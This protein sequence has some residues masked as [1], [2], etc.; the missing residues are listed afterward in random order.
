MYVEP[1][2]TDPPRRIDDRSYSRGSKVF[3]HS[4]SISIEYYSIIQSSKP[5]TTNP[6]IAFF[7]RVQYRSTCWRKAFFFLRP[8]LPIVPFQQSLPRQRAFTLMVT[9]YVWGSE[10]NPKPKMAFRGVLTFHAPLP[11]PAVGHAHRLSACLARPI[12]YQDLI[13]IVVVGQVYFRINRLSEHSRLEMQSD[14]GTAGPCCTISTAPINRRPPSEPSEV[15][16]K[17]SP[18]ASWSDQW[19]KWSTR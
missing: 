1:R 18:I 11:V 7:I 14:H 5:H 6:F 3:W 10:Q 15:K 19:T 16:S 13:G 8:D 12:D 2:P 17:I 9:Y 4:H